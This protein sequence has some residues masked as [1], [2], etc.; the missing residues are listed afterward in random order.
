MNLTV[1]DNPGQA[2]ADVSPGTALK[3]FADTRERRFHFASRAHAEALSAL[4]EALEDGHRSFASVSGETGTGKTCLRTLLH[5]ALD[6]VRFIRVSIE[7][8]LLDFD[9]LLLEIISQAGGRRATARE[10]PDRYARLSELKRLLSQR[11]AQTGRR[12]AVLLDEAQGLDPETLERLRL[13][14]NI[15][16]EQGVLMTFVLFGGPALEFT[17][18]DLPE[19][20]QRVDPRLTLETLTE[21]EVEAYVRH[22]LRV[23]GSGLDVRFS[24]MGWQTLSAYSRGLPRLVNHAMRQAIRQSGSH[25]TRMDDACLAG[26]GASGLGES[27]DPTAFA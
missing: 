23:A 8:S 16:T 2:S 18:G 13:L 3:A 10:L 14:S 12:L 21:R 25:A 26:L 22:R 7:S 17:L 20:A 9:Q 11:A 6:P 4:L 15:S 1:I 5:A 27:D 19:L 24:A